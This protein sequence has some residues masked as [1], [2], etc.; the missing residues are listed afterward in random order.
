LSRERVGLVLNNP[1]IRR[2]KD[3]M[4]KI[5]LSNMEDKERR[6]QIKIELRAKAKAEFESSLPMNRERFKGLFNYLNSVLQKE[7]CNEDHELTIW[8]LELIGVEN[9]DEVVGWLIGND[10]FCD[11]EVL[12]NVEERFE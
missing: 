6:R 2:P 9:V 8:F 4:S 1:I 11:C 10:G 7:K 12:A 3:E 5:E